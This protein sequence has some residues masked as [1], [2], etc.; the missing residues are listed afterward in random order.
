MQSGI[1]RLIQPD[2]D[3]YVGGW[4]HNKASG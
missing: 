2:G 3:M 4:R 1:G